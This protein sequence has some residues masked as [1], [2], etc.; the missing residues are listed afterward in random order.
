MNSMK[1]YAVNLKRRP[2]RLEYFNNACPYKDVSVIEAFDG[3]YLDT[4]KFGLKLYK[5]IKSRSINLSN[6]EIGCFVSHMRIWKEIVA[7]NQNYTMIFED[8]AIFSNQFIKI[9]DKI[10]ISYIDTILYIG[11]RFTPN[12]VMTNSIPITDVLIK[13]DIS[14]RWDPMDC[15][16]CTHAYIISYKCAKLLVD[17]FDKTFN[18][19][20]PVDYYIIRCV[21]ENKMNIYNSRP[22]LCHSPAVSPDSDIR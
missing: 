11:G 10:D 15:D 13:H 6:P 7:N 16:R 2:D 22:L 9:I 19:T 4:N 1:K 21:L 8:D 12:Y 18:G 14:K 20:D 3:K 5:N 17:S